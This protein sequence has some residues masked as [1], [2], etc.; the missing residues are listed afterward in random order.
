[1]AAV[2][3]PWLA[4]APFALDALLLA[5]F[6]LD[7][8]RAR[9][10]ALEARRRLPP[11][12]VQGD[13]AEVFVEIVSRAGR[14]IRALLREGLD[15]GL[16][17]GPLR[18]EVAIPPE[19]RATWNYSLRPRRRGN[20]RLEA[21]SARVLGPWALAWADVELLPQETA[22]VYPQ[23]RWG[24]PVGKLLTLAQRRQLGMTPTRIR[25]LGTEP[26]ALRR[27]LPGDS[28]SRIQWKAT[29]RHGRLIVREDTW[30]RGTRLL[31]LLDCA[32]SMASVEGEKSKLD[33][34]LAAALALTRIA[35]A[36]GDRVTLVTFSNRVERVVR[37]GSGAR[38]VSLAYRQ[39]YDAEA[40]LT[41]PA[42][43]LALEHAARLESRQ[44][45]VVLFTSVLDLASAELLQ[46]ALSE[47]RRRHRIV[48]VNL[49][50]AE[51]ARLAWEAP[52]STLEAFA[53]V[54][55]LEIL[56][57]NRDLGFRLRRAG[58]RVASAPA[59]GLALEALETYLEMQRVGPAGRSVGAAGHNID[60]V[61]RAPRRADQ[62]M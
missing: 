21:L 61:G 31:I 18:R 55:A 39:L 13:R 25:G 22:R 38:G 17:S 11:L 46:R 8:R 43:D 34:A 47:L 44:A 41:E 49:E 6:L 62:A 45:T 58:I 51:L 12:L 5:A 1:V 53:K 59:D 30:E 28:P 33:A 10:T 32:R 23:V 60:I 52:R 56:L 42:Y 9:R 36:R 50:D 26:Y 57:A 35:V 27:Y 7:G 48:L 40:R 54:S 16:A 2:V 14:P 19:G 20:H 15:P 4:P 29:A 3:A 24:G 37:V